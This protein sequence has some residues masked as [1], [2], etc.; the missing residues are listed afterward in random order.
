MPTLAS[1][2]MRELA[3]TTGCSRELAMR[4]FMETSLFI[5]LREIAQGRKIIKKLVMSDLM[6][7]FV[8]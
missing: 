6:E 2:S 8:F 5:H 1:P 4:E 3:P 7:S